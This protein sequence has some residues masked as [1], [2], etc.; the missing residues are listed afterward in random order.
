MCTVKPMSLLTN[1]ALGNFASPD[2]EP[3]QCITML[4][5]KDDHRPS[6]LRMQYGWVSAIIE[7]TLL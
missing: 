6:P 7:A 3:S 1:S 2:N 4:F 5:S